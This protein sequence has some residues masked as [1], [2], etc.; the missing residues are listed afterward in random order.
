MTVSLSYTWIKKLMRPEGSFSTCIH[1]HQCCPVYFTVHS[2]RLTL[3]IVWIGLCVYDMRGCARRCTYT[4][5]SSFDS[6]FIDYDLDSY[7]ISFGFFDLSP[8][9]LWAGFRLMVGGN[10]W[11]WLYWRIDGVFPL[12]RFFGVADG[13]AWRSVFHFESRACPLYSSM[14]YSFIWIRR[15]SVFIV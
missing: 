15:I 7:I 9:H 13:E 2:A 4:F 14:F 11:V 1:Q 5:F 12:F 10:L 6:L 3:D 8:L